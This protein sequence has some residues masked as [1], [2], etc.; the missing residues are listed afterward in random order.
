M[1]TARRLPCTI[2]DAGDELADRS[3]RMQ[4]NSPAVARDDVARAGQ[5]GHLH[6]QPFDRGI[7]VPNRRSGDPFLSHHVPR[8]ERLAQLD[9]HAAAR[10]GAAEGEP[11][12][13]MRREPRG[14]ERVSA[15]PQVGHDVVEIL[16][17]EVRQHEAVVELGAPAGERQIVGRLPERRD[18]RPQQELL[19]QAH[20]PVRGHLERAQLHQPQ[21]AAARV[22]IVELVD[23]ELGTV[24]IAGDVD[25]QVAE[26][27]VHQP[28]R[29]APSRSSSSANAISSSWS[30]S[31]RA[32]ST[33][34]C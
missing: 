10:D 28:R 9:V 1:Q 3:G 13:Q 30:A 17:Y 22:G 18:E 11:E 31:L 2:A 29:T 5:A 19:G 4:G 32:S 15:A 12:L 23:A 8:L 25:Q 33:R 20:A 27:P 24:R 16:R 26:H 7:H 14:L 21:P 34:G 6:L